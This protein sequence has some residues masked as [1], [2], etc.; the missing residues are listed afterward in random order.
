MSRYDFG[1][2]NATRSAVDQLFVSIRKKM[3]DD[4][5]FIKP[6]TVLRCDTRPDEEFPATVTFA[7][8]PYLYA[9]FFKSTMI[10]C[11]G[12]EN[13]LPRRL[14]EALGRLGS[15]E[16]DKKQHFRQNEG[17]NTGQVLWIGQ[18]WILLSASSKQALISVEIYRS[19]QLRTETGLLTYGTVDREVLEG[20]TI[21]IR[22]L[23]SSNGEEDR[24]IR[25]ID[26][27]RRLFY[28]PADK[29]RSFYVSLALPS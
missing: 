26:E 25:I 4:Q 10:H 15:A 17:R 13:C 20:D 27:N 28:L 7:S 12:T 29:C 16:Q 14:H 21:I 23:Q 2:D 22:D 9:D 3:L 5:W 19:K 1:A 8:V 18:T 11:Q 24:V 6:G